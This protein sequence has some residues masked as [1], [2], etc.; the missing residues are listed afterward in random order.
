MILSIL[1]I[2]VCGIDLEALYDKATTRL[3]S[4]G[5]ARDS[6]IQ[7][8]VKMGKDALTSDT[9]VIFLVSK[10][11]TKSSI[12]R[13]TL[14]DILKE[15]GTSAVKWIVSRLDYRGSDEEARSLKQSLWV[16][17]EIGG[18]E[19]VEPA[20]RF[21]ADESWAVRSAAFT[22]LGKSKLHEA[23]PFVL[24]GLNDTVALVRKSAYYALSEIATEEQFPSFVN[25]LRDE[26]YGVRYAALSGISRLNPQP[27]LLFSEIGDDDSR[28]YFVLSALAGIEMECDS[29]DAIRAFSPATRKAFYDILP[30]RLLTR[31][32][33]HETHPLLK[34]YLRKK[35]FAQES[36]EQ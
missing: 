24:D 11:D 5:A 3:V 19:I 2:S 36:E 6:A 4:F 32:L 30:E 21:I 27:A 9:T 12:E 20:A 8:F 16:L 7:E 34:T 31:S 10:F 33:K 29:L 15:I 18:A 13:H 26:Y 35:I 17:G 14:K 22:T 23:I 1:L 28:N 25:G